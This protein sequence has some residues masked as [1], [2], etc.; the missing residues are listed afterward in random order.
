MVIFDAAT[1]LAYQKPARRYTMAEL[2]LKNGI[3]DIGVTDPFPFLS[4]E[5]VRALRGDVFSKNVVDKYVTSSYLASCQIRGMDRESVPFIHDLWTHPDT[6]KACSEAAG[7]DLVPIMPYELGHTNIQ[8]PSRN[9]V[10]ETLASLGP[11]PL[12]A[13]VPSTESDSDSSDEE[14][15]G[16]EPVVHWHNDSYPWVCVVML[17]DCSTMRGGETAVECGDGTVK[18]IRGPG[19]GFAVMMQGR[20]IRHSALNAFGAPER[21]TMVTSFR[22]RDPEVRDESVLTTIRPISKLDPLYFQWVAYRMNLLAERF[23]KRA[24]DR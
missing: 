8:T 17:S 10:K 16:A 12:P 23:R 18:K 24:Q 14:A 15:R 22:A 1:H 20:Y 21:V 3:S 7:V 13:L 6:L 9:A 5:G 4:A 2:G 19:L 11:E